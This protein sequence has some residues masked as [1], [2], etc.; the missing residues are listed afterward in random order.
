MPNV[1]IPAALAQDPQG[2]NLG[3]ALSRDPART[4]M[5]WDASS[6]N[7]RAPALP[8]EISM[9]LPGRAT[10]EMCW[11]TGLSAIAPRAAGGCP[12]GIPAFLQRFASASTSALRAAPWASRTCASARAR[13]PTI[14]PP[15]MICR[16]TSL[17]IFR[18]QLMPRQ[19]LVEIRAVALGKPRCLAH[20]APGDLQDLRE[21]AARELV[22][23][24]VERGQLALRAAEALLHQFHGDDRC[25]RQGHVLPDHV[26]Q[27]A[28]IARPV[29]RG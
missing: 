12:P 26:R 5:R 17:E 6:R 7:V 29:G 16:S 25:L 23:R 24:L 11:R 2:R 8:W 27:L 9:S 4:P 28:D 20:V 3:L 18:R 15:S 1:A 21:I 19:Q 14:S 13:A 10:F 22:A